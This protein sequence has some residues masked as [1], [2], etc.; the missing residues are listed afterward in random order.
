MA[1]LFEA[2][3]SDSLKRL[4]QSSPYLQKRRAALRE[5]RRELLKAIAY[6]E[7]VSGNP[8]LTEWGQR[9]LV[10]YARRLAKVSGRPLDSVLADARRG[11]VR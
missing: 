1:K 7:E 6:L 2:I 11:L 9:Q 5:A 4:Q 8:T 10:R 3:S